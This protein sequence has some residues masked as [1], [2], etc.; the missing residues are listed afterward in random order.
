MKTERTPGQSCIIRPT[1]QNGQI[2]QSCSMTFKKG[3]GSL[4][5]IGSI[6]PHAPEDEQ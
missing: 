3:G 6:F 5:F 2:A 4:Q 1:S